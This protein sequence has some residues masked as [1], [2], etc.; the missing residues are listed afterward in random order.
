[1]WLKITIVLLFLAILASLSS[2]FLYL[3]KDV[4]SQS[5]RTVYA[6]GIRVTL[7]G[8]LLACIG[9]G[10]Y[11]GQLGSTAPWDKTQLR[12]GPE[13]TAPVLQESN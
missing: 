8:L 6:L 2:A 13:N 1:M 12:Q 10:L 9:Y 11:S 4:G 7:A 5:K 3:L